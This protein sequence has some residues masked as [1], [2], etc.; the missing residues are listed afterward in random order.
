MWK[1]DIQNNTFIGIVHDQW[2]LSFIDQSFYYG[3]GSSNSTNISLSLTSLASSSHILLIL[4][5]MSQM[6]NTT[7]Y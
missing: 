1:A 7:S 6:L 2:E 3:G 4:G 5:I